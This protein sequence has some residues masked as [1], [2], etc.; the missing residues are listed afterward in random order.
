MPTETLTYDLRPLPA[1]G[2]EQATEHFNEAYTALCTGMITGIAK[3]QSRDGTIVV[4]RNGP[5]T[6]HV[7]VEEHGVVLGDAT[8]EGEDGKTALSRVLDV[9]TPQFADAKS[10]AAMDEFWNKGDASRIVYRLMFTAKAS[11]DLP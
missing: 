5:Q 10:N 9:I 7:V 4:D 6:I 2:A 11:A 1:V 3:I 8:V